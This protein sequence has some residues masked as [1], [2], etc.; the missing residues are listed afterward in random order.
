M[1]TGARSIAR[2]PNSLRKCANLHGYASLISWFLLM[3]AHSGNAA[4]V[5]KVATGNAS[6]MLRDLP[7]AAGEQRVVAA[8]PCKEKDIPLP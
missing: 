6:Q 5:D 2:A 1:H 8:M 3:N 7:L 4:S